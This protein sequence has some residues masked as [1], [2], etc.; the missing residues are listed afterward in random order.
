[1]ILYQV[2]IGYAC[3]DIEVE[4]GLVK[5]AAGIANWTIGKEWSEIEDYYKRKKNA[6]ITKIR[7]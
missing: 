4:D 3:F 5:Y 6:K 7:I 2:D 1:M